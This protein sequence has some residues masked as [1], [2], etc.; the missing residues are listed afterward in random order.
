M[1]CRHT[2][3]LATWNLRLILTKSCCQDWYNAAS[4]VSD[5]PKGIGI[6]SKL[7]SWDFHSPLRL[8]R[9]QY[10]SVAYTVQHVMYNHSNVSR[11]QES[12]VYRQVRMKTSFNLE[13]KRHSSFAWSLVSFKIIDAILCLVFF[14]GRIKNRIRMF[15]CQIWWT[16]V[17]C[18]C[19]WRPSMTTL[20]GR[21]TMLTTA[22]IFIFTVA[23]ESCC[24]RTYIYGINKYISMVASCVQQTDF[25]HMTSVTSVV[26]SDK[27]HT[28]YLFSGRRAW[29]KTLSDSSFPM[30]RSVVY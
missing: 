19:W 10:L 3:H 15:V 27:S 12:V 16:K 30:T 9:W 6:R 11:T 23:A 17:T 20:Y 24:I 4:S 28:S 2:V 13:S 8:T 29:H 1:T 18:E 7:N 22:R 26:W 5:S 21:L 25:I 14:Q